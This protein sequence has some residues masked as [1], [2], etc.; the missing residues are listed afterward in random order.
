MLKAMRGHGGGPGPL[1]MPA[2]TAFDRKMLN[3]PPEYATNAPRFMLAGMNRSSSSDTTSSCESGLAEYEYMEDLP[4][5]PPRLSL[6]SAR[7]VASGNVSPCSLQR[8]GIRHLEDIVFVQIAQENKVAWKA[9]DPLKVEGAGGRTC[10]APVGGSR[11]RR[12]AERIIR[13]AGNECGMFLFRQ[14][15]GLMVLSLCDGNTVQ[16]LKVEDNGENVP[17]NDFSTDHFR[18]FVK[19]YSKNKGGT[20]PVALK[21]LVVC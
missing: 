21:T 18:R 4:V 16:H 1:N 11:D 2:G 5:V 7:D 8:I 10:S 19:H 20:L 6:I 12:E 14:S 9:V 3:T 17:A 15:K 13:T